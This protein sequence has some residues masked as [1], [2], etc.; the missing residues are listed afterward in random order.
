M[1]RKLSVLL[2]ILIILT[3][4]AYT[5][6]RTSPIKFSSLSVENGLSQ[7][8]VFD[9]IQDNKGF[10]WIATADGL[11][12]YDGY[13][14]TVYRNENN[15]PNSI[16]SDFIRK[17][18]INEKGEL[19]IGTNAGIASYDAEKDIFST[20]P[21]KAQI[22]SIIQ[23]SANDLYLA[24]NE[25]LLSYNIEQKAYRVLSPKGVLCENFHIL[26]KYNNLILIGTDRGLYM[27]NPEDENIVLYRKELAGKNIM[28]ICTGRKGIWI[29]TEGDGLY[30]I[31]DDGKLRNYR[32][33][34]NNPNSISSDFVRSLCF[35]NQHRLWVGTFVG[36]NI[37]D[38][39]EDTFSR[40]YNNEIE[41]RSINQNSV[42]AL[43]LD[44]QGAMWLGTFYG[45]LNYHHPLQ[46]QFE[47]IVIAY[48]PVWAIGTGLTASPQ[49]AKEMHTHIRAL[50][51][52]KYG[53]EIAYNLY[54]LYGGSCNADNALDLLTQPD[55]DGALVGKASLKSEEFI[56][57]IEAAETAV[58]DN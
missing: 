55:I 3:G 28:D 17:L 38:E 26:A 24:A 54:I 37:Y 23:P 16:Q 8:T 46:N 2:F 25:G 12:R 18:F 15:N 4:N 21:Y 30:Y 10:L 51:E 52:Q 57:I 31:S 19:W 58:K 39:V 35:D 7:S 11:N 14:F 22:N 13:T 36:L 41:K 43:Y 29:A 1:K 45:G 9:I 32:N 20:Y 5:N 33:D 42:R 49:Q 40:Y 50:V 6:K 48:E 56:G 44:N 27:M 47:R 34:K 53:T